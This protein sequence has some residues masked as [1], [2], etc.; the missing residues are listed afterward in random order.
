MDKLTKLQIELTSNVNAMIEEVTGR[1]NLIP[2]PGTPEHDAWMERA[3][4]RFEQQAA[5]GNPRER[6]CKGR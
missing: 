2:L 3:K 5:L 4:R 1:K 6:N